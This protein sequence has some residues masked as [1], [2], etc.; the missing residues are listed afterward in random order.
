MSALL[1]TP[2]RKCLAAVLVG[3]LSVAALAVPSA[4][5]K[6]RVFVG[7]SFGAPVGWGYVPAPIM[8]TTVIHTIR[9]IT[10]IQASLSAARSAPIITTGITGIIGDAVGPIPSKD[11]ARRTDAETVQQAA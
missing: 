4:P 5:A 3:M 7:F 9:P 1:R 2:W 6:A 8:V 10:V 11:R